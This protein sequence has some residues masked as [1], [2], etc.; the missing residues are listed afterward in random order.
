MIK[1]ITRNLE[2]IPAQPPEMQA[3][4]WISRNDHWAPF[5]QVGYRHPLSYT[6]HCHCFPVPS[7]GCY[8]QPRALVRQ[9]WKLAKEVCT[10]KGPIMVHPEFKQGGDIRQ[11]TQSIFLYDTTELNLYCTLTV[12]ST[13]YIYY[14]STL[15]TFPSRLE[16]LPP[17]TDQQTESQWPHSTSSLIPPESEEN[18]PD[19]REGA[20]RATVYSAAG[21]WARHYTRHCHRCDLTFYRQNIFGFLMVCN[22][23]ENVLSHQQLHTG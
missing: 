17:F 8:P 10:R 6:P 13:L 1:D 20:P 4:P 14:T 18:L 19:S 2:I 15:I 12:Y 5:R 9:M 11:D 21:L 23:W 7:P 22:E 3:C 16:Q